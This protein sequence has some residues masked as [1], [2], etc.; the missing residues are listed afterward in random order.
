M[1]TSKQRQPSH[2]SRCHWTV[3]TDCS[4]PCYIKGWLSKDQSAPESYCAD[5][6]A[7]R[8]DMYLL[9]SPAAGKSESNYR[10]LPSLC[11]VF[12]P[13]AHH[14]MFSEKSCLNADKSIDSLIWTER[15]AARRNL[16]EAGRT[17]ADV[18]TR[19]RA[20]VWII[21]AAGEDELIWAVAQMLIPQLLHW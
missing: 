12:P 1:S 4:S 10:E 17:G 2:F 19:R 16:G 21:T 15:C 5:E 8:S 6:Q 13:D 9:Q 3:S 20:S 11:S 14:L 18:I 7:D